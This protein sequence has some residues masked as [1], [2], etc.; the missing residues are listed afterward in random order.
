M[1]RK[2]STC[3]PI[4]LAIIFTSDVR[5]PHYVVQFCLNI[6]HSV[7]LTNLELVNFG[8]LL[9]ALKLDGITFLFLQCIVSF[10]VFCHG[11]T[12]NS[13]LVPQNIKWKY[14]AIFEIFLRV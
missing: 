1:S 14:L 11:S 9:L 6:N 13:N 5:K 8:S 3:Q 7:V 12:H 10:I 4:P 2:C